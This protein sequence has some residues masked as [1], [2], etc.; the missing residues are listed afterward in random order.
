VEI[1]TTRILIIILEIVCIALATTLVYL[2]SKIYKTKRSF[3]LLSLPIGVFFLMSSYL[4][5][6]AHHLDLS[7]RVIDPLSSSIMWLRA[8]TQTI[9]FSLIAV[10]Y[11]FA[12]RNQN[13][14]KQS[15]L[16]ILAGS[17]SLMFSALGVLYFLNPSGLSLIYSY[18]QLFSL[19]NIALLSYIIIF[20]DKKL[21]NAKT[22]SS[23]LFFSMLAF[24]CLWLG[25]IVF[26][27]F[28]L[29]NGGVVAL[30]GSQIARI[31]GFAIFIIIYYSASK[32]ASHNCDQKK[33]S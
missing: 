5:L 3:F 17:C 6:L 33:Q 12:S 19:V 16:V 10:S 21:L 9:G 28:A 8:V 26:L 18:T 22:R 25:Q 24:V 2:F 31:V 11:I 23:G 14:S 27:V 13:T 30:V 7:F 29:A 32:E 4:F 20:L 1:T 15:Y